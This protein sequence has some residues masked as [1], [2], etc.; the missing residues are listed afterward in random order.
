MPQVSILMAVHNEEAYLQEA[1]N[2]ILGQSFS[3]FEFIII[4]DASTDR[5]GSILKNYARQDARL[6]VLHNSINLG[7]AA[8]LNRGLMT[9][10]GQYVAR[11]DGD[12]I[13]LPNRL[14][15]QV[16]FLETNLDIGLLGTAVEVINQQGETIYEKYPPLHHDQL[17][18]LLMFNNFFEHSSIMIRRQCLE[19]IGYY[20]VSK[21][22]A[23]D[24]DLWGR[25]SRY[26]KVANL[27]EVLVRRRRGD[28]TR[29]TDQHRGVMLRQAYNISYDIVLKQLA[30]T[31][32]H[33]TPA[34]DQ[35][36][37]KR[38]WWDYLRAYDRASYNKFW[39]NSQGPKAHLNL[40]DIDLLQPF[41]HLLAAMPAGKEVGGT[42]LQAVA[43]ELLRHRQVMPALKLLRITAYQLQLSYTLN[44]RW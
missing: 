4:D 9:A 25:L 17:K 15:R 24:Y 18:I 38:F 43:Y 7:L 30:E 1:I 22:R 26:S 42:C 13:C 5:T 8:S 40:R 21:D 6:V 33:Q 39:L 3:D 19:Q 35:D 28:S 12:D 29:I 16:N 10:Q 34:L 32:P 14:G 2:S 37:F 27:P 36:A 23:E 44:C 41:W 11:L 31:F 20:D